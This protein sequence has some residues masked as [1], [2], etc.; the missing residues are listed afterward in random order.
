M[1]VEKYIQFNKN[2]TNI[3]WGSPR[4]VQ[5]TCEDKTV[6]NAHHVIVTIPLGVLKETHTT[7][8]TPQLPFSNSNSIK[9]L[10]FGTVNKII[11][12]FNVPFWNE[13]FSGF[14]LIWTDV[15]LAKFEELT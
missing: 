10:H 12:E 3:D 7:L 2:V 13:E 4:N 15:G 11:M 1:G 14:T 9:N 5:I 6:Y 8:F